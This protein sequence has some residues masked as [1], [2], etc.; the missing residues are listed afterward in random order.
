MAKRVISVKMQFNYVRFGTTIFQN[1]NE[2]SM[3]RGDVAAL[4]ELHPITI[5][6]YEQGEDNLKVQHFLALCNAFDLDPR[7]FFTLEM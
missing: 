1:R 4:V 6:Q 5:W 7:D 2:L 3:T